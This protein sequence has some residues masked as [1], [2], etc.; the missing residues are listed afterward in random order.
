MNILCIC[1]EYPPIGGGGGPVCQGV[2]ESIVAAGHQVDVV[3]SAMSD[4]PRREQR[5]GVEIYR[6]ACLRRHRHYTTSFEL[7][8]GLIPAYRAALRLTRQKQ[9]DLIH[10]HF[11]VP[12]GLVARA[13]ARRSGLPYIITAH[14]SDIPGYNPDRFDLAHR[15][16][17]PTWRRILR[18]AAMVT[19]PSR[20]LC[21]L[22]RSQ[23][24]VPV[25]IIPNGFTPPPDPSVERRDRILVVSR[26]FERKGV[27]HV[28][29]ALRGMQTHWRLCVAGDGPYLP[30]LKAQAEQAGV[31]VEFVGY[32]QGQELVNLYHS[33]KVFALP[34]SSEN[35]PV[36]LL[37]AMAA[38]CAV[39]TTADTGCAEVVGE[40]AVTVQPDSPDQVRQALQDLLSDEDEIQ[41]LRELA[42][43]RVEQFSWN[44]IGRQ[45]EQLFVRCAASRRS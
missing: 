8:T 43:R 10:C 21:D 39:L 17:Q 24:D 23:V 41:R 28:I 30:A 29:E 5:N 9:Y 44:H 45:F 27:Q 3:T 4:L 26:L 31:E 15:L 25:E 40:A 35:F 11:V 34:S 33:A 37:E 14:G 22:L 36:V 32:V 12:S 42:Q 7:L 6:T 19:T 16:I 20:F 38:G 1:Y 18:D 2:C 13:V